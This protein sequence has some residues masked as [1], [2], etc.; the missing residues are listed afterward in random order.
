MYLRYLALAGALAACGGSS[1]TTTPTPATGVPAVP[2]SSAPTSIPNRPASDPAAAAPQ[3]T[4]HYRCDGGSTVTTVQ[5]SSGTLKLRWN[6]RYH[7]LRRAEGSRNTYSNPTYSWTADG[8]EY[9]LLE[10][11]Q[12]VASGCESN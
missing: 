9:S 2:G 5:E 12:A 10:R 11:G 6:G 4:T 1:P 7:I 3:G 8:D